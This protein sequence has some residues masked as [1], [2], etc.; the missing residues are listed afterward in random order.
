MIIMRFGDCY[1]LGKNDVG[2]VNNFVNREKKK[3]YFWVMFDVKRM[4]DIGNIIFYFLEYFKMFFILKCLKINI[5][6][7]YIVS[8]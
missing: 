2:R 3:N 6:F 1:Y 7:Y 4:M 5:V 8:L